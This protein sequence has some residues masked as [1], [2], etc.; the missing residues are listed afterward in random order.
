MRSQSSASGNKCKEKAA[1]PRE[2]RSLFIIEDSPRV[3]FGDDDLII[4]LCDDHDWWERTVR[5]TLTIPDRFA[6]PS[7]VALHL[8]LTT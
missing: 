8:G 7:I 5:V 1:T 6:H 3:Y 4:A 2:S